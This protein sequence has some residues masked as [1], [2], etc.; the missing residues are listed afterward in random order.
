MKSTQEFIIDITGG[1]YSEDKVPKSGNSSSGTESSETGSRS[2]SEKTASGSLSDSG[3]GETRFINSDFAKDAIASL[4]TDPITGAEISSDFE[5]QQQSILVASSD[6]NGLQLAQTKDVGDVTQQKSSG[7][8]LTKGLL[9][10]SISSA[11]DSN[12]FLELIEYN[13]EDI[14]NTVDS[15]NGIR[16]KFPKSYL[17]VLSRGGDNVN[18]QRKN[19][20]NTNEATWIKLVPANRT[21]IPASCFTQ[22]KNC[23]R[24]NCSTQREYFD[25]FEQLIYIFTQNWE[26]NQLVWIDANQLECQETM[27]LKLITLPSNLSNKISVDRLEIAIQKPI[28]CANLGYIEETQI[29]KKRRR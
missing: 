24:N 5:T 12:R 8:E 2:S 6:L 21:G 23:E 4:L 27:E 9:I 20:T 22:L 14:L 29:K 13:S 1:N 3:F 7:H 15:S 17:Q 11:H 28:Q 18:P 26:K 25:S 19:L 16:L 10:P